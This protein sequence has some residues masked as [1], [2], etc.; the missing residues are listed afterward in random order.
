MKLIAYIHLVL[1]SFIGLIAYAYKGIGTILYLRF[2]GRV[3]RKTTD[4]MQVN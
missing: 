1:R 2:I 3:Q 4:S